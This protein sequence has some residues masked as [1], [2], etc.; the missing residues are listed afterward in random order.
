MKIMKK[1]LSVLLV[2]SMC[3]CLF[4]ACGKNDDA[5]EDP[6]ASAASGAA[7]DV[8]SSSE[9]TVMP[10]GVEVKM[11]DDELKAV[12]AAYADYMTAALKSE[13][14]T[15]TARFE[16]DGSVHF[17]GERV[18]ANGKTDTISDLNK[19][20]SLKECFAYLYNCG[21][22]DIDGNLLVG[23]SEGVQEAVEEATYEANSEA[24]AILD[25]DEGEPVEDA[26]GGPESAPEQSA[27]SEAAASEAPAEDAASSAPAESAAASDAG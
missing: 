5:K 6:A 27:E 18:D 25:A 20:A 12:A 23:V 22:V 11:N 2:L 14:Y 17:D 9:L 7:S 24:Q 8:M 10:E 13:G 26:K 15:V 3:L 4:A 1:I 21:Q 19:F 16:S